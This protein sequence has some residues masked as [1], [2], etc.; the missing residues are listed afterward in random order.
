MWAALWLLNGPL[1]IDLLRC[2][3]HSKRPLRIVML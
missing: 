3:V 2:R 1:A